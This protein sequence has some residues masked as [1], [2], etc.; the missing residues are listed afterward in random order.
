[1]GAVR[2]PQNICCFS[3]VDLGHLGLDISFIK[4]CCEGFYCL[5]VTDAGEDL[6][7]L[8]CIWKHCGFLDLASRWLLG[9][10]TFSSTGSKARS[11]HYMIK[12]YAN[13]QG[14]P[15]TA[16]VC[17]EVYTHTQSDARKGQFHCKEALI[18]FGEVRSGR[19]ARHL[20]PDWMSNNLKFIRS[21]NDVLQHPQLG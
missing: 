20:A 19:R 13:T 3:L 18:A 5:D 11:R 2:N 8:V 17:A 14:S 1:S 6:H 21:L 16:L 10:I 15:L 12:A 7:L 4:L 9:Q